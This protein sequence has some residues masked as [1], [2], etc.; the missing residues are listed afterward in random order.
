MCTGVARGSRAVSLLR[1]GGSVPYR[2]F[3]VVLFRHARVFTDLEDPLTVYKP[4]DRLNR[5]LAGVCGRIGSL[6]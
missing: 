4:L 6:L 5:L 3:R 1:G 2:G